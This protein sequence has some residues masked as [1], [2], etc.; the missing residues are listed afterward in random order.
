MS[1]L[2]TLVV[3]VGD[4]APST[5]A[6]LSAANVTTEG[7]GRIPDEPTEAAASLAASWRRALGH[8]AVYTVVD[9]DPLAAVV[10]AWASRLQG[11]ADHLELAIGLVPDLPSP[12]YYLVDPELG[13][14]EI[15]WYT[16][17]LMGIASSRVVLTELTPTRV[18]ESLASLP[19]GRSLPRL[20]EV[21]ETA[22][23]FVPLPGEVQPFTTPTGFS[24]ATGLARPASSQAATT[25]STSL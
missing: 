1:S 16:G 14:P 6:H 2:T 4:G 12:D 18:L 5:L 24:R 19:S 22:R 15:H 17:N 7:V 23:G 10:A 25:S 3:L 8:A 20:R 11:G 9:A 21:A 13:E